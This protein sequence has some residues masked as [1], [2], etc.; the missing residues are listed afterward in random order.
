MESNE[1]LFSEQLNK[2]LT[3]AKQH[4]SVEPSPDFVNRVM[5]DVYHTPLPEI[6]K[7]RKKKEKN[8]FFCSRY[9]LLHVYF[10]WRPVFL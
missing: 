4:S 1:P 3:E 2:L 6:E 9:I 5:R 10:Y 8:F 7:I